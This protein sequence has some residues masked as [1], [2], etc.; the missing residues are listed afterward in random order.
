VTTDHSHIKISVIMPVYNGEKYLREA[1]ES[2]LN[3]TF[4]NFELLIMDDGSTDQTAEILK[5]FAKK[6]P[7]IKIFHQKNSGVVRSLNALIAHAKAEILARMDADDIA[8]PDRLKIQYQYM[9]NHPETVVLGCFAKIIENRTVENSPGSGKEKSRRNTAFEE[10]ILNRWYLSVIPP[11]IH[12]A[13]MLRKEAFIRAGGY[14]EDEHPAEDYGLWIRMKHEGKLGTAPALLQDYYL[15][16]EGISARN[17]KK[18]IAKRDEL[19]FKNLEDLYK[20][21]EIPSAHEAVRLLKPYNLN[22]HQRRILAK[23]A[24]LTGCFYIEKNSYSKAK[25]Y[26]KLSLK[27]DPRRF[28]AALNLIFGKFKKAFLISIDKFPARFKFLFKIFWFLRKPGA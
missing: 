11:F 1:L 9:Q 17:Y 25:E 7:R 26:F 8:Y 19:N 6:D 20:N 5:T 12:S 27:M 21:N 23:L 28:D 4:K 2:I 18:Q 14:R 16:P 24:C 13:V 3:Q 15:H 10:D 22:R